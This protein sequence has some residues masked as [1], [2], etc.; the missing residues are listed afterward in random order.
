VTSAR[1]RQR[2]ALTAIGWLA[3]GSLLAWAVGGRLDE[4]WA[5][6]GRLSVGLVLLTV[7]LQIVALVA[8]GEAWLNCVR[9]AGG[10]VGRRCIYRA[11]GLGCAANLVSSYAGTAARI[12]LLRRSAPAESPC[13]SALIAAEVPILATEGV[14]AA[15]FS[16]T[17]VGPLGLPWWTPIV[18]IAVTVAIAAGLA[19]IGRPTG[20]AI[21]RGLAVLRA[22]RGRVR[23]VGFVLVAVVAQIARNWL[24]LHAVGVNASV[25]DAIAVLIAVVILGQLPIGP[26]AGAGAAVLI[27][28][29]QGVA[30]AVAAGLLLT[31][32]GTIGGILFAAW[33]GL[34]RLHASR[35]VAAGRRD[36]AATVALHQAIAGLPQARRRIIE[37]A[38]FGGLSSMHISRTLG[39]PSVGLAY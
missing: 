27:I 16:F 3:A 19:A 8:R 39:I 24:M 12:A 33:A 11:S 36:H 17:L 20:R 7:A 15:I 5:A 29:P 38:Y 31:A 18:A 14:L 2:L 4:F 28:G 9:G 13:V 1:P 21:F 30:A 37:N 34:D 10:T 25:F 26:T 32:T 35:K 23:L 6:A 22:S